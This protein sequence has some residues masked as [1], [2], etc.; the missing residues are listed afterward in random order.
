[1]GHAGL[2]RA[3]AIDVLMQIKDGNIPHTSITY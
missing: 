3:Q 1:M 2:N